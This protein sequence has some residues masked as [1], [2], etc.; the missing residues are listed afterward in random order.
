[1]SRS[2]LRTLAVGVLAALPA[3]L[4]AQESADVVQSNRGIVVSVSGLAS[5]IGAAILE[6][7]GNAVDAAVATAFA[8]AVT[9]PSAGNIGGGGFMVIRLPDGTATTVDYRERAPGKSTPTMYLGADGRINRSL[10]SAGWLAPGVPGTVRGMELAHRKYG[11]LPW[12]DVVQPAADLATNGWALTPALSR[13][14]NGALRGKSGR[15]PASVAAYGKPGGGDWSEGDHI[16]L[17][18]LGRALGDIASKGPDVFYTG[19]IA[20]SIDAQMR[21]NGGI[22]TRADLRDYKAVERAP[23][24]GT[25]LGYEIISMGPPSSGGTVMIQTLNLM[26]RMGVANV[27]PGSAEYFHR[28]IE[29]ARLA[30]LDRAR[31]LGDADFVNVPIDRLI[32][33]RY[34]DSLARTISLTKAASSVELGKDIVTPAPESDETTHFSVVDGN[35]MAVSHTYTLEGGY[36]SGVVIGGTGMLLNNEMGDFNK[37]PGETN[38]TGDIGT[39]ANVIAPGKRMLSSMSPAIVARNGQLV[40]VTGSPGGRTIPNTVLDVILGVT[41]FKHDVRAAVDGPRV[42]HQWLP[43]TTSIEA[44]GATPEVI[45]A[46]RE[47]GHRVAPPRGSQ[48]DAH[49]IFWDA[50]TK[51]AY[52]ANDKRTT[53]SKAAKPKG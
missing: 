26:E 36:G 45:S 38:R 20:D 13:S 4:L 5:D 21:R 35:G 27:K 10:T 32:S 16:R 52:G 28:R 53:D 6:K 39:P 34:A 33:A 50:A 11:K 31:H 18:D 51:T 29:A 47:M 42:H 19:W 48:G 43:D 1:M 7:G 40:L 23:V 2:L 17:G 9:H 44:T 49:S 15:F 46:L 25:F 14:I 41:L 37:K 24:K 3:P 30:Y 12:K 22:I 8:L